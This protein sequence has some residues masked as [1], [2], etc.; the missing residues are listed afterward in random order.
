MEELSYSN[1]LQLLLRTLD[2]IDSGLS[3]HGE[4]VAYRVMVAAKKYGQFSD[5]ELCKLIWTVL[6]HDIG[7]FHNVDISNLIERERL[8]AGSHAKYGYLFLKEY[9]P[10][11]DFAPVVLYHHS[12]HTQVKEANISEQLKWICNILMVQNSLDLYHTAHPEKS[13]E[14][15]LDVLNQL[16]T[17]QY[18]PDAIA[19]AKDMEP[20]ITCSMDVMHQE[21]LDEL[22]HLQ[23]TRTERA[24]F[25]KVLVSS[26]DFRSRV[27]ALHC[28]TIIEV[29][30]LL[31]EFCQVDEAD[32]Y[33]IHVGATI[34]DLGKVAIPTR[35][36]ESPDRLLGK[37]WDIM[38]SHV[39][40]TGEIL[41]GIVSKKILNIAVRHHETMDGTGYPKGIS[42]ADLTLPERIVA[43]ADVTSALAQER[44]YKK[45]F[46]LKEVVRILDDMSKN[47][48]LCPEVVAVLKEHQDEIYQKVQDVV[49][50]TQGEYDRIHQQMF[51]PY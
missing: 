34:H 27:T 46:P 45:A 13:K 41:D 35:I 1:F 4:R 26:I 37:D 44:S 24:A 50:K 19:F 16:S 10:Y 21:L 17:T 2:H 15:N 8:T 9:G 18:C 36:L 32:R 38:K 47:G 5:E 3:G 33:D 39:K 11:P 48:K 29:S 51:A 31:A 43:V 25:L 14:E 7:N 28:A 49:D 6:F 20:E 23:I 30:D 40:L 42:G 22:S 12:N